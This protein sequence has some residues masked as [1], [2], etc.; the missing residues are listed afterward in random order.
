MVSSH[1]QVDLR[2]VPSLYAT[3]SHRNVQ[4]VLLLSPGL[5]E[6]LFLMRL[7]ERHVPSNL[8]CAV[9]TTLFYRLSVGNILIMLLLA[10]QHIL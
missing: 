3:V 2:L 4:I 9:H 6:S 10:T 5:F 8:R 7:S 1:L